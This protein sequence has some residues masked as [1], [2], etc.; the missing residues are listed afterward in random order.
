MKK[1]YLIIMIVFL[2]ACSYGGQNHY[3]D[4]HNYVQIWNVNVVLNNMQRSQTALDGCYNFDENQIQL[5]LKGLE[6]IYQTNDND[7]V[8]IIEEGVGGN[9]PQAFPEGGTP[10]SPITE[11]IKQKRKKNTLKIQENKIYLNNELLE[12]YQIVYTI[13][14]RNNFDNAVPFNNIVITAK[15][16]SHE[17]ISLFLANNCIDTFTMI[18]S[19]DL[20]EEGYKLYKAYIYLKKV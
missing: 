15:T 8:Y 6:G 10:S 17:E 13:K 1:I 4:E 14:T 3:S 12:D 9:T 2:S 20:S 18:E 16:N 7:G 11:L 19:Y 5:V